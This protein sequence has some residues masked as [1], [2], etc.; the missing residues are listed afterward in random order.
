MLTPDPNQSIE[1][2]SRLGSVRNRQIVCLPYTS[3]FPDIN[4][5]TAQFEP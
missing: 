5:H 1:A 2:C 3:E 4:A